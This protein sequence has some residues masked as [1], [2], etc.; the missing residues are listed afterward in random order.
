MIV[1]DIGG[2]TTDLCAL[3]P[4]GFPRQAP[5]FVEV[6]GVRTMFS[7]P[8]VYSIAFGGGSRV[9][10]GDK[11]G[12]V[13]FGPDSVAHFLTSRSMVFGGNVMTSTDIAVAL[14]RA[15]LG[16]E[17]LVSKIPKSLLESAR[18]EIKTTLEVVIDRMK[19]SADPVTVLLV[20]GGSLLFLDDLSGVA[21]YIC[22]PHHGS[23]NAV[24]AAMAKVAGEID[25]IEI[26][27]GKDEKEVVKEAGA[28]AIDVA[29]R[30]G[31]ARDNVKVVEVDK[32]PLQYV[33]N[34]ATRII[35]K[36]TGSLKTP[37]PME[38]PEHSPAPSPE[39][40]VYDDDFEF[41]DLEEP[42]KENAQQDSQQ[43]ATK[44]SLNINIATYRPDVRKG[45]W[46][47]SE[48]DLEFIA[49]GTGVLGTGGGG[50]SYVT[51]LAALD[52]LHQKGP[53]SMRV[54]SLE[55][56]QDS[57]LCCYGSWYGA[58][59][60][61]NERLCSGSEVPVA[62]DTTNRVLGYTDFQALLTDEIGGGN[63]LASFPSAVHYDK[64][65][66]DGDSMGRAYPSMEHSK[67]FPF[68]RNVCLT[69]P[70]S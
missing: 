32:I 22:P 33:A 57:D 8:E 11:S 43:P 58:P 17:S 63:G 21:E 55:A 5:G 12:K 44:Q 48:V 4:S 30:K 18:K 67:H 70:K 3:L 20:G 35:I 47:V 27:E 69:A 65:L 68:S 46:Y 15:K 37:K 34:K 38:T 60:S 19:V 13:T 61:M 56:L 36:A 41:E 25:I 52:A 50:S 16:D 1:I 2:T 23:A 40:A 10:T 31:A 66:V 51:Y 42:A 6:G 14:G 9:S 62:I 64:P 7:M 28:K 45:V 39:P 54:I 49:S 24:G 29:V 53:G 26:L 59:S